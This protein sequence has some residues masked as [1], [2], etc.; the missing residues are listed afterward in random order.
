MTPT[1]LVILNFEETRRRSIILWK[2]IPETLMNWQ[3]DATAISCIQM[4]RHVLESEHDFHR[5]I[6]NRGSA[7]LSFT[8]PWENK[9]LTSISEEIEFAQSFRREFLD[10]VRLFSI[11]DLSEIT[12]TRTELG[13]T[14]NLGDYLL[15]VAYHEA[16]HSGQ[17]LSYLRTLNIERPQIWD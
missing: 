7:S 14:R 16:V 17:L 11:N 1:D 9:P 15:R 10:Y 3:P 13:Q 4:V 12:I 8:S 6:E 5:I 2:A